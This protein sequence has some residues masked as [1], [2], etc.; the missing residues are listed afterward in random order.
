[1]QRIG[2]DTH[3]LVSRLAYRLRRS[4][5]P[6][7]Q[8]ALELVWPT[9]CACC[10]QLGVLLC[11]SCADALPRIDQALACPRCGAPHGKLVCTECTPAYEPVNFA[12]EQACC[13]LEFSKLTQRLIVA[14]KDGGE[15]RLA[16]ILAWIVAS[17]IPL[18]WRRWAD[19]L[20]WV[21]ADSE[22]LRRRGFD[23]MALIA[24]ALAE[25]SGLRAVP[26][27]SKRAREDQRSLGRRQRQQNMSALFAL[28]D[29][30]HELVGT[31]PVR[32]PAA[33]ATAD[34]PATGP[35]DVGAAANAPAT[36]VCSPSRDAAPHALRRGHVLLID[37]VLTTGATLDAAAR[38]LR[39]AGIGAVRVA[40]VARVW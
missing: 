39:L 7:G 25:Q 4:A 8:A 34:A 13:A 2:S 12:F 27:L 23:H 31:A 17:T 11:P 40:A 26:L 14:Y 36:H 32:L 38:T 10:E 30:A 33:R 5:R 24:L 29:E 16:P 28:S 18:E 9:R 20:T 22:A 3:K 1:M 6:L 37:D 21:P 19:A 15:R 35:A